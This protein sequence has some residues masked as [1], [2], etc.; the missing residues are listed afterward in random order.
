MGT[1]SGRGTPTAGGVC[2]MAV[3]CRVQCRGILLVF[4]RFPGSDVK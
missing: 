4:N 3:T 2:A 1:G